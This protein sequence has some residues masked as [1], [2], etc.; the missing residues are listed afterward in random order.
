MSGVEI[1]LCAYLFSLTLGCGLGFGLL[2][3]RL[4]DLESRA[5]ACREPSPEARKRRDMWGGT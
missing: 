4:R 2:S 3:A 5:P 1:F